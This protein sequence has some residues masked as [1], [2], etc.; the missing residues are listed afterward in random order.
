MCTYHELA[1][2]NAGHHVGYTVIFVQIG[3]MIMMGDFL[4]YYFKSVAAGGPMMLPTNGGY[5]V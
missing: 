3:H 1:E 5:N 4:Y 2:K